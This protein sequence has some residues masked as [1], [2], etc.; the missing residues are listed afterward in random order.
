MKNFGHK[1]EIQT[2]DKIYN[3]ALDKNPKIKPKEDQTNIE[4]VKL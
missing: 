4:E 3:Q 2:F 1:N